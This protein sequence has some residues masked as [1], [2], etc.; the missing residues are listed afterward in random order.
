[1]TTPAQPDRLEHGQLLVYAGD[2]G[3]LKF[4]ARLET[5][6]EAGFMNPLDAKVKKR[7]KRERGGKE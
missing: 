6:D 5:R 2:E 1:M 3:R 7:P 4:D